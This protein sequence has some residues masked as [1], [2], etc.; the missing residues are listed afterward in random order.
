[1]GMFFF[2]LEMK[3]RLSYPLVIIVKE[4][5]HSIFVVFDVLALVIV[6]AVLIHGDCLLKGLFKS[7]QSFV[8]C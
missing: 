7:H 1:M 5:P 2:F 6:Q 8:D 4:L 3:H